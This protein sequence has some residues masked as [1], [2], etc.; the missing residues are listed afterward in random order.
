MDGIV[1]ACFVLQVFKIFKFLYQSLFNLL[2]HLNYVCG[3]ITGK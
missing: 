2:K 1:E 3:T